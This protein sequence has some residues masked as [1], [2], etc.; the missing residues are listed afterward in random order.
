M[1]DTFKSS[2][3]TVSGIYQKDK[4]IQGSWL[5]QGKKRNTYAL[6]AEVLHHG[7]TSDGYFA[8]VSHPYTWLFQARALVRII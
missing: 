8:H 1:Q 7:L 2:I 3:Y 5:F 6:E 4:Q